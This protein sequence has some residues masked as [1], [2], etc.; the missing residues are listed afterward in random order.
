[1]RRLI[2]ALGLLEAADVYFK[3]QCPKTFER[4]GFP[5]NRHVR[6]PYHPEAFNLQH[7][8][9]PAML[10]RPLGCGINL[11]KNLKVLRQWESSTNPAKDIRLFASFASDKTVAPRTSRSPLPTP[12]NYES[13]NTLMARWGSKIHHPN[14]KRDRIVEM[15]RTMGKSDVN[16]RIWK[17]NELQS[18]AVKCFRPLNT[19]KLWP[20]DD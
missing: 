7:K 10:G 1:M 20:L 8:I 5:L 6:I 18:L 4:E 16:A 9:R 12:H 11:R 14:A 19:N 15:L 13:E 17:S 2:F 3:C